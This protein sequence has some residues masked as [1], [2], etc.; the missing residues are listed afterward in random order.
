MNTT[1]INLSGTI[2]TTAAGRRV[3]DVKFNRA[4]NNS[5]YNMINN[6]ENDAV[7]CVGAREFT[8]S[9]WGKEFK[10]SAGEWRIY[11]YVDEITPAID[12][13]TSRIYSACGRSDCRR[14]IG[15]FCCDCHDAE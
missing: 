7:L 1:K 11:C 6:S 15:E 2:K 13:A 5:D 8:F 9:A 14:R 3:V 4:V 10:T 12:P